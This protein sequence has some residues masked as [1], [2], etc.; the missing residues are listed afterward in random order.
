MS[1]PPI[2]VALDGPDLATVV[3]WARACAPHIAV[4]KV[5]LESYLRD[6]AAGVTAIREASGGL[7]LFLDL[8][9]HDIPNTVAG[10]ARSVA[11][12]QPDYLTVHASGGP[13]MI[14]AAVAALPQTR[15]TAVTVLTSLSAADMAAIGLVG[16][17]ADAAVRL[18]RLAVA[19]GARAIVCSPAEVAAVRAAVPA[20]IVLITPGVRPASGAGAGLADQV[21]V[22]T[23]EQALSDGADMLVI[24][25]PIT[26]AVDP[27]Q[28]AR[29]LA[30]SLE[31]VQACGHRDSSPEPIGGD[32]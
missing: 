21:R 27:R 24:G 30:A 23:P 12:L 29:A 2:A 26:A 18:A 1:R 8:K 7:P 13:A 28:A 14:A 5:G 32:R 22:A 20:D 10:A 6:G 17:P 3:G 25:R 15:I 16:P 11:Q 9:L 4:T 31:D 19:A